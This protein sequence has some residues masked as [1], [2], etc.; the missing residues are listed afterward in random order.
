MGVVLVRLGTVSE[1]TLNELSVRAWRAQEE[2]D[3]VESPMDV[4]I[5]ADFDVLSMLVSSLPALDRKVIEMAY[6]FNGTEAVADVLEICEDQDLTPEEFMV[7][8]KRS[9]STIA[10]RLALLH[11]WAKTEHQQ[12]SLVEF[13]L[14]V[15]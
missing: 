10:E 12:L 6:G 11:K 14:S 4:L 15:E 1:E 8:A 5:D 7:V 9:L 13:F 3:G 2:H